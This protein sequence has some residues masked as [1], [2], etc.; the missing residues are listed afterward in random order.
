M[1]R[2]VFGHRNPDTDT[3]C[4]AILVSM[5]KKSRGEDV[6]AVALG[7]INKETEYV[8]KHLKMMAPRI[9]DKVE[10][11]QEVFLV[12]HNEF[13][14]SA[15]NI[16]NARILAVYD[17]H[18][19]GNFH[20][21]EPLTMDVRPV[22]CTA[23]ILYERFIRENIHITEEMAYLI[24]SAIISDTLL[25]KSPTYTIQDQEVADK[26]AK[27]YDINLEKYGLEM[28]EA[29]TVLTSYT[30]DELLDIDTK[31]FVTDKGKYQV[32][33]INTVNIDALK[34]D[35]HTELIN[36]I[37]KR[38]EEHDLDAFILLIT[39][40]INNNSIAYS[41]GKNADQ[42]AEAFK[43]DLKDHVIELPGVVSRK[44]QVVPHL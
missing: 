26:L 34:T 3:I 19:I 17:H 13:G 4:S 9:I 16:E 42:I 14:Q 12:D 10:D 5:A 7:E 39:D 29:G 11:Q 6:E 31:E 2:L 44:K 43:Q 41:L 35:R 37:N 32:G 1:K 25:F 21:K 27:E 33:Q 38:I 20:T 40:I 24:V 30:T 22:G 18:R 28:L 23:T 15:P 36:E 8:L